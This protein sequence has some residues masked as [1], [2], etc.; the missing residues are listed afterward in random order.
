MGDQLERIR[1]KL[2]GGNAA[3]G[4]G[5]SESPLPERANDPFDMAIV[6]SLARFWIEPQISDD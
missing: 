3:C 1:P 5:L 6:S 4:G 2:D